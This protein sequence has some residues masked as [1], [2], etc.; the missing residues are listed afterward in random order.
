MGYTFTL[1]DVNRITGETPRRVD[2]WTVLGIIVPED[3]G[4]GTGTFRRYSKKNCLEIGIAKAL[5]DFGISVR[6]MKSILNQLKREAPEIFDLNSH[7]HQKPEPIKFLIVELLDKDGT[8]SII[9]SARGLANLMPEL[10]SRGLDF[11]VI[12]LETKVSEIL[13]NIGQ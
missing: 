5:S 2:Y 1:K 7:S 6:I 8:H 4:K 12:N 10:E 3:P 9:T 11:I 13:S